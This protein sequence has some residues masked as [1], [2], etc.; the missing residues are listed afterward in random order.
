MPIGSTIITWTIEDEAGNTAN[1]SFYV[2]VNEFVGLTNLSTQ[3][4]LI[5]PNPTTGVFIVETLQGFK[6]L[7]RFEITDITGKIIYNSTRGHAPLYIEN[8]LLQIDISN[9]PAGIYFIQFQNNKTVLTTKI[10]KK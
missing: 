3:E 9:Q 7:V 2:V 6:N 10:I 5:Y 8:T 4:V 1:C